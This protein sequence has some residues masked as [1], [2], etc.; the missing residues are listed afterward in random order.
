MLRRA[1]SFLL[2]VFLFA[3]GI[4]LIVILFSI[5]NARQKRAMEKMQRDESQLAGTFDVVVMQSGYRMRKSDGR[6]IYIPALLVQV[7]NI[8]AGPSKATVIR[9]EFLRNGKVFCAASGQIPE[10]AAGGS[11]E[12]WLKCIDFV[13]FGSIARGLSLPETTETMEYRISLES[14]NV[15]VIVL[16]DKLKTE[17][18]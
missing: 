9:T 18:F 1:L 10:L 12:I 8:S 5:P 13:V 16:E 4:A 15:S 3:L 14:Q 17:F 7:T 2:A 6:D 11:S